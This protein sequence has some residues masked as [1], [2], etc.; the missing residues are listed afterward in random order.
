MITTVALALLTQ[1]QAPY[2]LNTKVPEFIGTQWINVDKPISLASRRGKVTLVHFWTFACYNCKNDLPALKTLTSEFKSKDVLTIG[3]HTPE[4]AI[5]KD[6]E[7]V[8]KNITKLGITYPVLIDGEYKNWNAWKTNMWPT[9][10]VLD[11]QGRLRGG[12]KGEMNYNNQRGEDKMR[13]LINEL[14]KEK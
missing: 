2:P 11:K 9:L 1:A 5:E 4:I 13:K 7:Q 8:K 3:I 6:V 12:W 10:Y 14:L